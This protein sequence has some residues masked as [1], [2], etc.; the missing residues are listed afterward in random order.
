MKRTDAGKN[1]IAYNKEHNITPTTIKEESAG[2]YPGYHC[3]RRDKANM[4]AKRKNWKKM[5]KKEKEKV[6][7]TNGEG[8]AGSCESPRFRAGCRASGHYL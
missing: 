1:K 6:I 3:C 8:D 4:K 2:C 7:E 5:S